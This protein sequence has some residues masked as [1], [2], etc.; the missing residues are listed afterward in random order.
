MIDQLDYLAAFPWELFYLAVEFDKDFRT[1]HFVGDQLFYFLGI[2]DLSMGLSLDLEM[3]EIIQTGIPAGDVQKCFYVI[4]AFKVSMQTPELDKT[5]GSYILGFGLIGN[6]AISE[7]INFVIIQF[8]CVLI[9]LGPTFPKTG[10]REGIFRTFLV[11]RL[12]KKDGL[13]TRY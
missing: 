10:Y 1:D 6:Q 13:K 4:E 12:F 5:V 7:C 11:H 2:A 8:I 3:A 9:V